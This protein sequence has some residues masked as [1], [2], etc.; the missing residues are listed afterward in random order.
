LLS[1]IEIVGRYITIFGMT[2]I[3]IMKAVM[4]VVL[5][6]VNMTVVMGR[7]P[8]QCVMHNFQRSIAEH[9]CSVGC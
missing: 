1:S 7:Q 9:G 4:M 8:V 3:V 6:L 5:V 2:M